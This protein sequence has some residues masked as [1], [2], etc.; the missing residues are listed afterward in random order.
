MRETKHWSRRVLLCVGLLLAGVATQAYAVLSNVPFTY[1]TSDKPKLLLVMSKDHE[2]SKKAYL[3]YIDVDDDGV[4]DT[5]Y[6]KYVTYDGYFNSDLCYEYDPSYVISPARN[7]V[8]GPDTSLTGAFVPKLPN[9]FGACVLSGTNARWLGNFMNWATMTRMDL[10]RKVLYGGKRVQD[11]ENPGDGPVVLER[12]F[13]PQDTHSFAKTLYNTDNYSANW[14]QPADPVLGTH[15][16]STLPESFR[17]VTY[18]STSFNRSGEKN[19]PILA[20][21]YFADQYWATTE[22][23]Q[24]MPYYNQLYTKNDETFTLRVVVCDGV[25][26]TRQDLCRHYPNGNIKPVGLLQKYGEDDSIRFGLMTG[27]YTKYAS[28][29]VLRK[30]IGPFIGD[31]NDNGEVNPNTGRF[32]RNYNG[33]PVVSIVNVIDQIGIVNYGGNPPYRYYYRTCNQNRDLYK[34]EFLSSGKCPDWGNPLA[35]M[36]T[37]ALKYLVS[38]DRT[39][40]AA[41]AGD[42]RTF[43]N[44]SDLFAPQD[45][46]GVPWKKDDCATCSIIMLASGSPTFDADDL[47]AIGNFN[48]ISAG[49]ISAATNTVASQEGLNGKYVIG[50]TGNSATDDGQTELCS[51]KEVSASGFADLRGICPEAPSNEGSFQLAG[52]MHLAATNSFDRDS[53]R[54]IDNYVFSLSTQLPFFNLTY[55]GKKV[56][57]V[58]TCRSFV[59]HPCSY[60]DVFMEKVEKDANGNVNRIV[61]TI[62]WEDSAWGADYDMDWRVQMDICIGDAC[63]PVEGQPVDSN[64]VRVALTKTYKVSGSDDYLGFTISGVTEP[65]P[66][67]FGTNIP[68][69]ETF[70]KTFFINNSLKNDATLPSPLMLAAKYGRSTN[71]LD[72][73]G[74]PDNFYEVTN[75]NKLVENLGNVFDYISRKKFYSASVAGSSFSTDTGAHIY[76]SSY[77]NLYSWNGRFISY[78]YDNN[79]NLRRDWDAANVLKNRSSDLRVMLSWRKQANASSG[80]PFRASELGDDQQAEI[81]R[82]WNNGPTPGTPTMT[83]LVSFNRGNHQLEQTNGDISKFFRER[84]DSDGEP[85]RLGDILHSAAAYVGPP[86]FSLNTFLNHPGTDYENYIKSQEERAEM[87]YV[88]ANDG[89]LHGFDVGTGQERIAY[90]PNAVYYQLGLMARPDYDNGLNHRYSVDGS[91]T[92]REAVINGNWRTLLASGLNAG[93][94]AVFVLDVTDP[95]HFS[96]ANAQNLVLWEFDAADD[97]A[98]LNSGNPNN[99]TPTPLGYTFSKPAIIKLNNGRWAAVFGNGY[100]SE[101]GVPVLYMVYLDAMQDRTWNPNDVIRLYTGLANPG[102][103]NGLSNIAPV[104]DDDN[105][106]IDYIYAGDL[107]GNVWRFDISSPM[108]ISWRYGISKVF[109]A[110][111]GNNNPQPITAQPEVGLARLTATDPR[112]GYMVYV[113]TGKY[114]DVGDDKD[115]SI[116]SF[117]GIK[118]NL[119]VNAMPMTRTDLISQTMSDFSTGTGTNYRTVSNNNPNGEGWY[120]DLRSQG[121]A[122]EG[123]RVLSRALLRRKQIVFTTL[124]PHINQC[125]ASEDG[126][127][128][129]LDA[130]GGG[131]SGSVFDTNTDGSIDMSDNINNKAPAGM[132]L[133]SAASV[134]LQ[135]NGNNQEAISISSEGKP[136]QTAVAKG[137]LYRQQRVNWQHV[138]PDD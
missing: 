29:G 64:Q 5:A 50:T 119:E 97:R 41:F 106:T 19:Q 6:N 130:P 43:F 60:N 51:A 1:A 133:T 30:P 36:Y 131:S 96:E 91:P 72:Q 21:R 15:Q 121:K 108:A 25:V 87:V 26:D 92:L 22:T 90:V 49:T 2:M 102:S 128:M 48:G 27:G 70:Y 109:E 105:G 79:G 61:A 54:T 67:N 8:F 114:M 135:D 11:P 24:C 85:A 110:R 59:I 38:D 115:L 28:G 39:P 10:V 68:Q 55:Q 101:A 132:S 3:D 129:V 86:T 81:L 88:G 9:A 32:N 47:S 34:A 137:A 71:S 56:S 62:S 138:Y 20:L 76:F 69:N 7:D 73:K 126:W 44:N 94:K 45:W 4:I 40:T 78:S 122:A 113:G 17:G 12:S 104:D 107:E 74:R 84:L 116:Q 98:L 124:I 33:E 13:L 23:K 37:E 89:A 111:D 35:E 58:M 120:L 95:S 112:R 118:D 82:G 117:Y 31:N 136:V 65:G 123:E 134:L 53:G 103:T 14:Y 127:L 77:D 57:V 99:T 100:Y 42:D 52:A 66:Y 16:E 75:F 83:N 18:C 63:P 46:G 80:I 93:G 125:S